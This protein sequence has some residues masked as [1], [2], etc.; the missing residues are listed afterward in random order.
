MSKAK[1]TIA[2]QSSEFKLN[3]N[4][5]VVSLSLEDLR[6]L[7][8]VLNNTLRNYSYSGYSHY[9]FGY[10]TLSTAAIN[11]NNT[12]TALDT[13]NFG[14]TTAIVSDTINTGNISLTKEGS[15]E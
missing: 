10:A 15:N 5:K 2:I 1:K 3:I 11:T 4:G 8:N 12:L 14:S 6:S 9:P 7:Q 13:T